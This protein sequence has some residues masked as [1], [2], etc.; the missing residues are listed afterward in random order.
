ME[1][2]ISPGK[3]ID[4]TKRAALTRS[5]DGDNEEED[6]SLSRPLASLRRIVVTAAIVTDSRQKKRS[7][8]DRVIYT[9]F[10]LFWCFLLFTLRPSLFPCALSLLP[11]A[12][13]RSI[14]RCRYDVSANNVFLKHEKMQDERR[15]KRNV[16]NIPCNIPL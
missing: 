6:K 9:F 16:G 15:G 3:V 11:A 14:G 8:Q 13:S 7:R 5:M 10:A 1:K 2:K 4:D 12:S